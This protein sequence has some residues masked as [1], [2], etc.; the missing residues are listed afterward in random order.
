MLKELPEEIR[1]II[2]RSLAEYENRRLAMTE[3]YERQRR[4]L[5]PAHDHCVKEIDDLGTNAPSRLAL[6]IS[7]EPILKNRDYR[8]LDGLTKAILLRVLHTRTLIFNVK[9][10]YFPRNEAVECV[11]RHCRLVTMRIRIPPSDA[12]MSIDDVAWTICIL[13]NNP[14]PTTLHFED[15]PR[16]DYFIYTLE[17]AYGQ[18]LNLPSRCNITITGSIPPV[19]AQWRDR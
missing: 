9:H 2:A 4:S 3:S 11:L 18:A 10:D 17:S 19:I 16:N 13:N 8:G 7:D 15:L 1:R 5:L 12:T 14:F 6:A